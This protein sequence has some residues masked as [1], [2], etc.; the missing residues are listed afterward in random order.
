MIIFVLSAIGLLA[1]IAFSAYKGY[2]TG[3][4]AG[5]QSAIPLQY[6][7]KPVSKDLETY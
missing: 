4:N 1:I 2:T 6:A 7:V 3:Y 5:R